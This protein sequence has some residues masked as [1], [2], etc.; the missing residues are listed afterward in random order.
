M[1]IFQSTKIALLIALII[2]NL[3]PLLRVSA[4][5][6]C[7]PPTCCTNCGDG[8][9][10]NVF[11]T[12]NCSGSTCYLTACSGQETGCSNNVNQNCLGWVCPP[13]P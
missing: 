6:G 1:R 9:V 13:A 3:A 4:Q 12:N 11:R 7:Q 5:T 2:V 10:I 8:Q